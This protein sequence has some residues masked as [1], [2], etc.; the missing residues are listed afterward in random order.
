MNKVETKAIF[1][2]LL[3]GSSPKRSHH[4]KNLLSGCS[5]VNVVVVL[6]ARYIP[7]QVLCDS[8]FGYFLEFLVYQILML[9]VFCQ[10]V[11]APRNSTGCCVMTCTTQS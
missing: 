8:V 9:S 5:I 11:Q 7:L 3:E 6:T 4:V 2:Q 1:T 10:M